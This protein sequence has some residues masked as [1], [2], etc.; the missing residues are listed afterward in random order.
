MPPKQEIWLPPGVTPRNELDNRKKII[1][2]ST[3]RYPD[4]D[5]FSRFYAVCE[6]VKVSMNEILVASAAEF[7]RKN[8]F[9]LERK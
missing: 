4:K 6:K 9:L 1:Q 3:V 5:F 2:K 7:I 8:E